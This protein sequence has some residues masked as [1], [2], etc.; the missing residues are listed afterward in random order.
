MV[1]RLAEAGLYASLISPLFDI[2]LRY[3]S[4]CWK[5]YEG[6]IAFSVRLRQHALRYLD[7]T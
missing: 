3:R 4:Y 1:V 6:P 5:Q 2:T 7:S